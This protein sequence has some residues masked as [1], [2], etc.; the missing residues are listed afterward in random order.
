MAEQKAFRKSDLKVA[1]I[2]IAVIIGLIF[3][4]FLASFV[5]SNA[6]KVKNVNVTPTATV[7]PSPAANDSPPNPSVSTSTTPVS[8]NSAKSKTTNTSEADHYFAEAEKSRKIAAELTR[9]SN[10]DKPAYAKYQ[11]KRDAA[12]SL[13]DYTTKSTFHDSRLDLYQMK[14]VVRYSYERY[15]A[16]VNAANSEYTSTVLG[17]NCSPVSSAVSANFTIDPTAPDLMANYPYLAN[18]PSM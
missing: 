1:A 4:A 18:Y 8:N 10:I 16:T 13:N 9:C 12:V 14:A 3:V 7:A 5:Y 6:S 2:A 15:N 17:A 11:T